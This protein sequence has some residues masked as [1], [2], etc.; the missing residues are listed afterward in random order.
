MFSV[1]E[2]K[3]VCLQR[4]LLFHYTIQVKIA[5]LSYAF[6]HLNKPFRHP[7]IL[8]SHWSPDELWFASKTQPMCYVLQLAFHDCTRKM[9]HI[10]LSV[11]QQLELTPRKKH[12]TMPYNY[13]LVCLPLNT[14]YSEKAE[15][16]THLTIC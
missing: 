9:T 1:S 8:S 13:V 6:V 10:L 16:F 15:T 7:G 14:V 2:K 12:I 4:F 11:S 3:L 5:M